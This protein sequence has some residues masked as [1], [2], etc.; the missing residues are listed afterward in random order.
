MQTGGWT[1]RMTPFTVLQMC[2]LID[3]TS[4]ELFFKGE[5]F[6]LPHQKI[7]G[8]CRFLFNGHCRFYL[9]GRRKL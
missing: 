9:M 7:L 3:Y 4:S 1:D 2:L 6:I 5:E 8:P